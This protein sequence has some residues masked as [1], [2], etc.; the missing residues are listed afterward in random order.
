MIDSFAGVQNVSWFVH[1]GNNVSWFVHLQESWLGNPICLPS[2]N[3]ARKQCFLVC[4]PSVNMAR[5]LCFLVC[6]RSGNM[7]RKQCF[8]GLST[9]HGW[10]TMFPGLIRNHTNIHSIFNGDFTFSQATFNPNAFSVQ[11]CFLPE[12]NTVIFLY[13][14]SGI[15]SLFYAFWNSFRRKFYGSQ[16]YRTRIF[17]RREPVKLY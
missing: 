1:L 3:M 12:E 17:Y 14:S 10:E 5:K 4:P 11:K 15:C 2:G 16:L 7:A 6:P 13:I 8:P 9:K